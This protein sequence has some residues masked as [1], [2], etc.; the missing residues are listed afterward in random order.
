MSRCTTRDGRTRPRARQRGTR[1]LERLVGVVRPEGH[2]SANNDSAD[3]QDRASLHRSGSHRSVR[4]ARDAEAGGGAPTST[5]TA[6]D[7][8][9]TRPPMAT[10]DSREHRPESGDR[11][12]CPT[13]RAGAGF[14]CRGRT[15][16]LRARSHRRR[17]EAAGRV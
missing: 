7:R 3:G 11:V 12:T 14:A 6:A 5:E 17:Y 15:G 10:S 13:C 16:G 2:T 4:E 1:E 8:E 9:E